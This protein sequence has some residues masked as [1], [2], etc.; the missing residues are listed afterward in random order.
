MSSWTRTSPHAHHSISRILP[1]QTRR[2]TADI[3]LTS[4]DG[5]SMASDAKKYDGRVVLAQGRLHPMRIVIFDK[6]LVSYKRSNT[7]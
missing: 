6:Y 1:K 5:I 2:P 3:Q 7:L 4:T